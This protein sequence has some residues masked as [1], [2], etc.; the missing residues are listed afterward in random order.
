MNTMTTANRFHSLI[1]TAFFSVLSANLAVL[2]AAADSVVPPTVTVK[3]GDLDVSHPQGAAVLYGRIRVAAET[4][5][6]P[7]DRSGLS[8]KLHLDACVKRAVAD[9]VTA[10]NE[11]ALFAVYSAKMGKTAPVRIASLHY[12]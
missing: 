5:C 11:P 6:S 4:V 1:A 8:A 12:R 10:V 9:A 2:P 7:Y 3:F